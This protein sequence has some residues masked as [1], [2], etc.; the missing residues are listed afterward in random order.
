MTK[1]NIPDG[2]SCKKYAGM[3]GITDF[4]K[5]SLLDAY[6]TYLYLFLPENITG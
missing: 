1:L 2:Q 6:E 5:T 3:T 4:N